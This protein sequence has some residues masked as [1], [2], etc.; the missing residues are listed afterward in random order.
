MSVAAQ[1]TT[2][3]CMQNQL[4]FVEQFVPRD[5][6]LANLKP[7]FQANIVIPSPQ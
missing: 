5:A 7:E 1:G 4:N 6:L 2:I 3:D